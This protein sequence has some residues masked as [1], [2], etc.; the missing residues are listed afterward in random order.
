MKAAPVWSRRGCGLRFEPQAGI[1]VTGSTTEYETE[2]P[3]T[4]TGRA[5]RPCK[6]TGP[7]LVRSPPPPAGSWSVSARRTRPRLLDIGKRATLAGPRRG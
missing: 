2:L 3:A 6:A 4:T 1:G 7:R 5:S